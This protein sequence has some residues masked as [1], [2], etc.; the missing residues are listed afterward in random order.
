MGCLVHPS[1][2]GG[3]SGLRD[4]ARCQW[5]PFRR[6]SAVIG[7][8]SAAGALALAIVLAGG[9]F[10]GAAAAAG[11]CGNAAERPWCDTSLAAGDRA[12]LLL[13]ALTR[14]E[15]ISLLGGDRLADVGS[16]GRFWQHS[17]A[18]SGI[19]RLGIPRVNFINGP[20][21]VRQGAATALPAPLGLAATFNP[22]LALRYGAVVGDEA[23]KKDNDYVYAPTVNILRTPLNGRTF[24]GYGEDP[25][26]ASE[27]TV[28]WIEGAQKQGVIGV[29]KHFAANN[30]EG[31]GGPEA[32][33]ASPATAHEWLAGDHDLIG[34]RRRVNVR[35]DQRT[36]H[37]V[38]YPHF[39]A[40]IRRAD[41]GA[42]MCAHNKVNGIHACRNRGLLTRV[43]RNE[44]GFRGFV[45][46][47]YG[48]ARNTGTSLRNGLDFE[49]FPGE[50]YGPEAVK[51]TLADG[52]A[53]M[54]DVRTH[55][56]RILRTM[57]AHGVFDRPGYVND[58]TRIDVEA[59][60]QLAKRVEQ[61]A[62]TLLRNRD[63]ILPLR[64]GRLES[65]AVIGP[66]AASYPYGGGS[67]TVKPFFRRTPLKA[68]SRKVSARTEVRYDDG[69]APARAAEAARGADVAVV[70]VR[71]FLVEAVDRYCL[72]LQC[73]DDF[74]NQDALIR[75]VADANPNTIVVLETGGPVLTPWRDEIE[76][77]LEA[78]YPGEAG[79][80]A[81]TRVLFGDVDPGGRLP[82]TFP[83]RAGDAPTAG[84]PRW[85]PGIDD[86]VYYDEG[87]FVGY[88][89][90]D[91]RGLKPAFPFG[92]GRSYTT[93]DYR[94]LRVEA[95]RTRRG[96]VAKIRFDVVNTG[97]REGVAV[98]Q[99]YLSLPERRGLQQP[100]KTL[101]GFDRL[102][103][104]P[105][106]TDT[107]RIRLADRAFSH[108][109][110]RAKEWRVTEGCYRLRVGASSRDLPL[111]KA[112]ARGGADCGRDG[113]RMSRG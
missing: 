65:I 46:S 72:T 4:Y 30:Q 76:G 64:A 21:G 16:V 9:F 89:W 96:E 90:Y 19:A 82:A 61:S 14:E 43:L 24:E 78:W 105:G 97:H 34:D 71:D 110:T 111:E 102:E 87:V 107:V 91:E 58:T 7:R 44:W 69:S 13:R 85:Y 101:A 112:I 77:L 33:T 92:A 10:A 66:G 52:E 56:F 41:V 59:H 3:H 47:D 22:K 29:V 15:T 38:F 68:I 88:R 42:V 93:F 84:K 26:L 35:V 79:G 83:R 81:I 37:E 5:G 12:D 45:L 32:N 39:E 25:M 40:A 104:K 27:M 53:T 80:P 103:L 75:A 67:S 54:R 49:P 11:R 98:P 108:W 48:A 31:H 74:G 70:F 28:S 86:Q 94:R 18:S 63:G 106:E 55:V 113:A 2:G 99:V 8:A 100:P 36:L 73:P 50:V 17:G 20:A 6:G 109:V 51:A 95:H 62:I 23:K 1:G 57:F 60:A